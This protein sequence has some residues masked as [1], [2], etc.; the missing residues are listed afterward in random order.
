MTGAHQQAA[1]SDCHKDKTFQGTPAS[2]SGCHSGD[3]AHKGS[4]GTDCALCHSTSA[5]KPATFN[6][7]KSAFPL[8]GAH[9]QVQC[10]A[11]HANQTFKGTPT[12]CY[13]CHSGDDN[14][15]G[16]FGKD[17]AACH[18]TASWSQVTFDH[19]K[20]GFPLTGAHASVVCSKCHANGFSGTPK[21]CAAC[22]AEPTFHA[23]LSGL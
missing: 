3:D 8:T 6:H 22:H 13:A 18:V 10:G 12:N 2:C 4:L 20:S 7:A 5:W 15:G 1:C 16:K 21:A 14:H 19:N 11:C 23:G 9:A 17:C